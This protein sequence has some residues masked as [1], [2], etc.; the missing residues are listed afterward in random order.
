MRRSFRAKQVKLTL[1]VIV[2]SCCH[3]S[4]PVKAGLDKQD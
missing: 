1:V 4:L 2:A 3:L